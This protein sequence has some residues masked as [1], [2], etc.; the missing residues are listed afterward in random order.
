MEAERFVN[1]LDAA[2][3]DIAERR[4]AATSEVENIIAAAHRE[5]A[6]RV[7]AARAEADRLRRAPAS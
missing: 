6:A 3:K 1:A 5:A 7:A 2:R 4:A